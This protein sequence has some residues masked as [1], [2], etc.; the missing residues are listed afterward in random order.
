MRGFKTVGA[1]LAA[2][3]PKARAALRGIRRVVKS[4]VP[5]GVE[6]ISYGIPAVKLN[7]KILVYFAAF[8]EH[9][10]LFPPVRGPL[11]KVVAKY[12][13]SK[14]NLRFP[15]SRPMPLGL[16]RRIVRSRVAALRAQA[17]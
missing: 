16:I 15:L 10:G 11:R 12:A 1:Y 5:G 14:G 7:G 9:V 2:A 13:G 8:K 17:G 6:Q 3:S 4:A